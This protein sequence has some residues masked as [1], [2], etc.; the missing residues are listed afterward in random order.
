YPPARAVRRNAAPALVSLYFCHPRPVYAYT[1]RKQPCSPHSK[2]RV[3]APNGLLSNP[4]APSMAASRPVA[5]AR[6]GRENTRR[7]ILGVLDLMRGVVVRGIAGRREQYAPVVSR[8]C[9]SARPAEVARALVEQLGL[10][11]LYLAD[12][13]AIP[14]AE[15]AWPVYEQIRAAGASLWI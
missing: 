8:L 14:G 12:L 11:E 9:S 13:D 2:S 15:P 4:P 5:D 6:R 7:R 3:A 10:T 1:N